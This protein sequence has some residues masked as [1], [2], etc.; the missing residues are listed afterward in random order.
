MFRTEPIG[1]VLLDPFEETVARPPQRRHIL[2][3][4]H[5]PER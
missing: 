4:Q 2:G 1:P 5:Q 3:Q